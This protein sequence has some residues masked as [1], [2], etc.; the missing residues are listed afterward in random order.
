MY[1]ATVFEY[2]CSSES[3]SLDAIA[4]QNATPQRANGG[5]ISPILRSRGLC[6]LLRCSEFWVRS[7]RFSRQLKDAHAT[8]TYTLW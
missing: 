1:L 8:Y 2:I 7:R 4:E 3:R 5:H 6:A